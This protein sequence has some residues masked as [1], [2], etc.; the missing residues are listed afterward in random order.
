MLYVFQI[1]GL[2][3]MLQSVNKAQLDI[4]IVHFCFTFSPLM[5]HPTTP[6][7]IE[8]DK[9]IYNWHEVKDIY[10]A[11]LKYALITT[12]FYGVG[13]LHTSIYRNKLCTGS[14][15]LLQ[16][17]NTCCC[18]I[19]IIMSYGKSVIQVKARNLLNIPCIIQC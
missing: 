12:K 6:N 15:V 3:H 7:P 17:N 2:K 13:T 1:Y 16:Y 9:L 14:H 4:H 11:R 5:I 18:V 10:P 19:E 8:L